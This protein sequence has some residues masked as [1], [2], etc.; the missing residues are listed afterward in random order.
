MILQ[1]KKKEL[2]RKLEI[3]DILLDESKLQFF[4]RR[5]ENLPICLFVK[6]IS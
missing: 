2:K 3:A 6:T 5:F 4:E 1:E